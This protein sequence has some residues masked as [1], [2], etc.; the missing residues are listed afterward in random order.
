MLELVVV[1][2]SLDIFNQSRCHHSKFESLDQILVAS[3]TKAGYST[4]KADTK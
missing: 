3:A 1:K 4:S 2:G